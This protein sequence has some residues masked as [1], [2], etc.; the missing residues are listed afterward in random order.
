MLAARVPSKP[1]MRVSGTEMQNHRAKRVKNSEMCRAPMLFLLHRMEFS[2]LRMMKTIPGKKQEVSQ[3]TY[4]QP[5][6]VPLIVLQRRTP[7]Y[8]EIMPRKRYKTIIPI[9]SI[10]LEA[11]VRNPEQQTQ[12]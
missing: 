10:P 4:F 2:T 1:P 6:K 3:A 5:S 11:G 12:L 8:P 9:R 7:T